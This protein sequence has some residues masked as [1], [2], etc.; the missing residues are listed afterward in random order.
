ML[1]CWVNAGHTRGFAN[2]AEDFLS[3]AVFVGWS[4]ALL[5]VIEDVA[6]SSMMPD[7][8]EIVC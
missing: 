8:I 5:G 3:T 2:D 6:L 4:L 7:P 1:D